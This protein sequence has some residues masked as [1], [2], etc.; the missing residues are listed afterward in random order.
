MRSQ[1][2]RLRALMSILGLQLRALMSIL[3]SIV[4][5]WFTATWNECVGFSRCAEY[6]SFSSEGIACFVWEKSAITALC[7]LQLQQRQRY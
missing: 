5:L 3:A 1:V 2:L 7:N 4:V 6:L